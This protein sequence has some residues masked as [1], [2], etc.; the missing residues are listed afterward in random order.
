MDV[1]KFIVTVTT[2][3]AR[4][5]KGYYASSPSRLSSSW[6]TVLLVEFYAVNEKDT[7]STDIAQ[8][9]GVLPSGFT[10]SI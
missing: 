8:K 4:S 6:C 10:G 3:K 1:F 9:V 5:S 7:G 2:H